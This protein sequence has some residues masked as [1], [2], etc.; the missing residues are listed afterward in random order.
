M[1]VK[2]F[3]F[4]IIT[5]INQSVRYCKEREMN[6]RNKNNELTVFLSYNWMDKEKCD[7][8]QLYLENRGIICIRDT[9]NLEEYGSLNEFMNSIRETDF[10]I[11]LIGEEY[12]KSANCMYE[13]IQRRKELNFIERLIPVVIDKKIFDIEFH[14]EI[15]KYWEE[16]YTNIQNSINGK[17]LANRVQ[18][19]EKMRQ[20]QIIA[21]EIGE[22]LEEICDRLNPQIGEI[23]LSIYK[24]I[25]KICKSYKISF[26]FIE[27]PYGVTHNIYT[28]GKYG[29]I[30]F[31]KV[32]I[33][34]IIKFGRYDKENDSLLYYKYR[35]LPEIDWIVLDKQDKK[36]LLV[37]KDIIEI[38]P[39]EKSLDKEKT[40]WEKCS[41]NT[42]LNHNFL[43]YAFDSEEKNMII[44]EEISILSESEI[45]KYL[46]DKR[47]YFTNYV[48]YKVERFLDRNKLLKPEWWIRLDSPYKDNFTI[49]KEDGKLYDMPIFSIGAGVR[50]MIWVNSDQ[51]IFNYTQPN[52]YLLETNYLNLNM[53][54]IVEFGRYPYNLK[55]TF[56]T[57]YNDLPRIEW[58][59]I[60]IDKNTIW[61]ITKNII[62]LRNYHITNDIKYLNWEEAAINLWL[63][64]NDKEGFYGFAFNA[65]EKR[66]IRDKRINLLNYSEVKLYLKED[67]YCR[68]TDYARGKKGC[69]RTEDKDDLCEWWLRFNYNKEDWDGDEWYFGANGENTVIQKNGIGL[70]MESFTLENGIRPV[71][72]ISKS[73]I[74]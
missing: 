34:D 6:G 20:Y 30:D 48:K 66:I 55:D 70:Q 25:I 62:D 47:A 51:H 27:L 72:H 33:F 10:A 58:K 49:V 61:L 14:I 12:L 53:G 22:I 71:L 11:M 44:G 24:Y 21:T 39:Y 36:L 31:D 40:S 32:Q 1:N 26:P 59:V 50:P 46:L 15:I 73:S 64:S 54:D 2:I 18:I 69:F 42:W 23:E 63:N 41:L 3:S 67:T 13:L 74:Q 28:L 4:F 60:N 16:K 38:Y 35:S 7:S 9:K 37:S 65:E 57:P 5:N 52:V 68:C 8:I 19:I 56:L 17:N 45:K 29:N 43:D